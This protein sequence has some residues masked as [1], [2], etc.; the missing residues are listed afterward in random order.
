MIKEA[1]L[2][3]H[4][5]KLLNLYQHDVGYRYNSD[6]LLLH[7]FASQFKPKGR[8]LDV[9]SGCGIVGLLL[10][11]D[12]PQIDLTQI[13]IQEDHFLMNQKS[14]LE[15]ALDVTL[16][17]GDF[18]SYDFDQKFDF[19]VSNPP[20]YQDGA[21]KSENASL[22]ISRYAASLPIDKL[23]KRV[24]KAINPRGSFIFCYDAKQVDRVLYAILENK[25]K[26]E[27]L[28]FVHAKEG[29]E[30]HLM[31]LHVKKSSK[32]LTKVL[33][34]IVLYNAQNELCA[35]MQNIYEKS[36]TKSY[37]WKN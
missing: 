37:S 16:I 19:V 5:G 31:L 13:E 3:E 9:G 22:I 8:L 29:K 25:F 12:F 35:F 11:R 1:L 2:S 34:P 26:L 28:C 32:S 33:A 24:T 20:F 27:H 7:N 15:N 14:A 36:Q 23:L 21:K 6:S 30:A 4:T 10:K 18:L 17:H